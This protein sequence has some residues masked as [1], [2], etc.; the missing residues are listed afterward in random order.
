MK[1]AVAFYS[2]DGSTRVAA[3]A[4]AERLGAD[5]F[6]LEEKKKRVKTPMMFIGGGFAAIFGVRSR[7]QDTFADRMGEYERILIGTPIWAS[8]PVP[9]VNGFVHALDPAGK[10]VMLFTVQA[11]PNPK[12][13]AEKGTEKLCEKIRQKGGTLL[14]VLRLHG[15]VP[16]KT[17]TREHMEAQLDERLESIVK[18]R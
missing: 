8:R 13:S 17:A 3:Q 7:L 14:P 5:V 2:L 12:E 4:I 11:D 1:T 15:E 10:L 6:E 18:N 9:A 16:E